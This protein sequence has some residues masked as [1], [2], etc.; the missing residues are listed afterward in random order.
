MS[1]NLWIIIIAVVILFSGFTTGIYYGLKYLYKIGTKTEEAP[2]QKT[3]E[4]PA[5][6][7]VTYK[8]QVFGAKIPKGWTV[9]DNESGID[10][11]DPGDSNTGAAGAVAVGWFGQQ[12]PD[13]FIDFML[14]MIGASSV[15]YENESAEEEIKDPIYGLTWVMKTK[16]F[17]FSKDGLILKAKASAGVLNGYGQFTGMITAFQTTPDKWFA[18][19]PT[20]ERVAQSITIINPS[21]AG[22]IDKVRL[23]TAAD[24][25]NDSSPLMDSWNYRNSSQSKTSHKWSDAIMGQ[26]SDLVSPST[27]QSYTLP[28]NSYDPTVGGYRNPDN[29]GEILKDPYQ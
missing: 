3:S 2:P 22:G 15:N 4:A 19:S 1:K 13:G 25:A 8:G 14:Q 24:L 18:W 27:G 12:T 23:P 21:K 20:L 26:E 11:L 5:Y 6:T 28:L 29:S 7:L 9:Q 17:T 10:I 16:T